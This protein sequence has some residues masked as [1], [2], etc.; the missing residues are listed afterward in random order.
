VTV[1]FNQALRINKKIMPEVF[2]CRN[3]GIDFAMNIYL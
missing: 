2:K 1:N 3:V